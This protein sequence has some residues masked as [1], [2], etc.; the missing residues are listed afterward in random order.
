MAARKLVPDFVGDIIYIERIAYRSPAAGNADGFG[1]GIAN[2]AV[3]CHAA[4]AGAKHMPDVVVFGP[5]QTVCDGL[6]FAQHGTH[7]VIGERVCC[8]VQ[9]NEGIVVGH[10][11]HA[12]GKFPLIHAI[13]PVHGGDHSA[14]H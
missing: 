9:K 7:I 14:Q 5:D 2:H 10:Y 6:V 13:D 8:G 1:A 4:A 11:V 3:A 12:H